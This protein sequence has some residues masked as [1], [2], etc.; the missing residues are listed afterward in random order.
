MLP[1][2]QVLLYPPMEGSR[3]VCLA[4]RTHVQSKSA[5]RKNV[6]VDPITVA[7]MSALIQFALREFIIPWIQKKC[8]ERRENIIANCESPGIFYRWKVRR[9]LRKAKADPSF[10]A[11][12][13]PELVNKIDLADIEQSM[14]DMGACLTVE[15]IEEILN[16][17]QN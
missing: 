2:L 17:H 3:L 16:E 9:A 8:K 7:I 15:E 11:T 4:T 6:F 5:G 14:F 13:S 10:A 12:N 1:D